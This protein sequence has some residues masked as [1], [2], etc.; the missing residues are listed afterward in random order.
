[1]SIGHGCMIGPAAATGKGIQLIGRIRAVGDTPQGPWKW[2]RISG[3]KQY[4]SSGTYYLQ[5][6]EM[7]V[8]LYDGANLCTGGTAY[9]DS[10]A[11]T[12]ADMSYFA[13][14]AFDGNGGTI[15]S[16]AKGSSATPS[17]LAY[18]KAA[19]MTFDRIRLLSRASIYPQLG[20]RDGTLAVSNDSTNGA[21]G[22]WLTLLT[23]INMSNSL[24][25]WTE[26]V[27]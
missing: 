9:A 19:G 17:W 15:W 1:M 4:L 22:T 5:I 11:A 20:V 18:Y 3:A 12:D 26:H 16:S 2:V 7:E 14:N 24:G 10:N 27:I 23:G 13:A 21:D 8:K 6:A 25:T